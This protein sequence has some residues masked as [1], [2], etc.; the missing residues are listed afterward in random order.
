MAIDETLLGAEESVLGSMLIDPGVVP[1]VLETLTERDM[2]KPLNRTILQAI[3]RLYL[4]KRPLDPVTVLDTVSPGGDKAVSRYLLDLME[5]TATAA[6]VREY[7][8]LARKG[9]RLARLREIGGQLMALGEP[10]DALPLLRQ[11]EEMLAESGRQDEV[12]MEEALL[13]F[14]DR[15]DKPDSGLPWGLPFL[16]EYL[17]TGPGSFV[18]LG[19]RPSDGKTALAIHMAFAQAKTLRVGFF[20]L[21]DDKDEAFDRLVAAQTGVQLRSILSHKLSQ[22]EYRQVEQQANDLTAHGLDIIEAA[23]WTVEQ[24]EARAMV[25]RFDVIYVDYLQLI[26]PSSKGRTTRADEVADISRSLARMARVHNIMVVGLSQLSRPADKAKRREPVLADLRE[27]GQLEQD[28]K[29]VMFIWREDETRS[30][31]PRN[32]SL[33]K[34]KT[35]RLKTWPLE[36]DGSTQRFAAHPR[37]ETAVPA[38][39]EIQQSFFELAPEYPTPWDTPKK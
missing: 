37:G 29:A 6:N 26:A 17:H 2:V 33:Q 35:G 22:Q 18:I 15:M 36:F 21:E 8:A 4:D 38:P 24:I 39:K 32:L 14:Y 27:S 19:G 16:E 11:G 9:A 1:L 12:T 25:R 13:R 34:N 30:D 7:M 3:R 5:V 20:T 10:E 28:A 23:G 31:S